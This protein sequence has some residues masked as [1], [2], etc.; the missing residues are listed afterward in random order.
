MNNNRDRLVAFTA[1]LRNGAAL[2]AKQISHRFG[3]ANPRDL[4]YRA[5]H[6]HGI[7]V[8]LDES[9][10]NRGQLRRRYRLAA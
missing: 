10:N 3:V 5:R 8:V 7:D 6:D 1:A 9:V 2:T 4:V